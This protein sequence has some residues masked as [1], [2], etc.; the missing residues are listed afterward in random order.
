MNMTHCTTTTWMKRGCMWIAG[1]TLLGVSATAS[2]D[3]LE[4]EA[5]TEEA[6]LK[7]TGLAVPQQMNAF[8]EALLGGTFWL[9][10]RY[11]YENVD[12]SSPAIPKEGRASTLRS[13]VGFES[14]E[15][16]GFSGVLEFSDVANIHGGF[17]DYNDGSGT[18]ADRGVVPD[19]TGTVVNQ[20]YGQY[21]NFLGGDF[22]AGRQK[23]NLDNQRFIGSVNWRQTEQTFDAVSYSA[24]YD[25]GF[26]AFYAYLDNQNTVL[27]SDQN[28]NSHLLN[29]GLT[30]DNI[31]TLTGY[32]YYLDFENQAALSTFTY[33]ARFFGN[34]KVDQLALIYGLEY[35]HQDDAADNPLNVNANY[36]H[37]TA[38][39]E[40]S[41][42]TGKIGFESLDGSVG[43]DPN[44]AFQTP[45]STLHIHN[46]FADQFLLTPVTGLEDLYF[47]LGYDQGPFGIAGIYHQFD[48]ERGS[49]NY[50][51]EFDLVGSY[52]IN[53]DLTFGFK[54]AEFNAD[55]D[56]VTMNDVTKFWLW[57]DFQI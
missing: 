28:H 52:D 56:A 9:Q 30:F 47:H 31:G 44:A 37:A 36:S 42:I 50:G 24:D 18:P 35:A 22:K 16:H 19:P 5:L 43:A 8:K 25:S 11:R 21:S 13:R 53:E 17:D 33:G 55:S 49:A 48:A 15:Y 34:H 3:P 4:G 32:G 39:V 41:G 10:L 1:A 6:E 40:A 23:I 54:F 57:L 45:L 26:N 51:N 27:Q 20:V 29:A 7:E 38:G 12:D 46:G 2:T 14:A